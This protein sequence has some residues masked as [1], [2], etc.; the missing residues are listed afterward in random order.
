[1]VG[2]I[3]N[4]ANREGQKNNGQEFRA[5]GKGRVRVRAFV[6]GRGGGDFAV[7]LCPFF[8]FPFRRKRK[9][10]KWNLQNALRGGDAVGNGMKVE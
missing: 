8:S 5:G 2:V 1:M 4:C 3:A 9:K 7:N 6:R 10:S